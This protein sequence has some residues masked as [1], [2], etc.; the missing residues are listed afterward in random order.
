MAHVA[1]E[2]VLRLR[3]STEDFPSEG[4]CA[5]IVGRFPGLAITTDPALP[6]A[7]ASQT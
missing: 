1:R 4:D 6:A 3:I 7:R 5:G 2:L